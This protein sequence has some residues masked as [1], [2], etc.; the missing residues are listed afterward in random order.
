LCCPGISAA[1]AKPL[2]AWRNPLRE[3]SAIERF[4]LRT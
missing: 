4:L 2:P 3:N 1:I